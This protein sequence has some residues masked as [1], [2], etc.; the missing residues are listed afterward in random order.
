MKSELLNPSRRKAARRRAFDLR[1][2]RRF[3]EDTHGGV[4]A[5]IGVMLPILLA[6]SGLALDGSI[7]YAQKR[8]VQAIADT[9]AYSVMLEVQRVGNTD[10]AKAAAKFDALAYGFDESAGDSITFNIPP[11][12]GAFANT[13]GYY[14]VIVERPAAVF[15]TGLI[16]SDFNT[17][18][19]AVSGGAAG[20]P[21]PCLLASD[22]TMKDA[23]K[24]NNGTVNTTGCDIQVNSSDDSALNV[25]KN[26]TLDADPINIV[27]DYVKKG[28]ITSTPNVDMPAIG[29][30]LQNLATPSFSP[31][32]C[33]YTDVAYSG[34]SHTLGPGVYCGGIDLSG[35]AQVTMTSG[36]Y[37]ISGDSNDSL[38]VTGQAAVTGN[39][40]TAYFAGDTSLSVNG[41]GALTLTAPTSGDYAGILFHGDPASDPN[42]EH[43]VTGNGS[44]ILDGIMYFP[45]AI[46]KING[47]GNTTS[48]SEISA[49]MARQLRFGG[50]GTLNFHISEDAVLPPVLQSKQTLV[51]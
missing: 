17:A 25:A 3:A 20:S 13:Q 8:S 7:W 47:N 9:A 6:V 5:Y 21:P 10:L 30:P 38:S 43:M 37:I 22:P 46:A 16:V 11:T 33:D 24:V 15:L 36:T 51:E 42:T 40:I 27:G 48:N 19:R 1:F 23:F 4:L 35:D 2:L 45:N 44:A 49:I 29:D 34:G 14:E 50:N 41:Q 32:N 28:T 18:A 12:S 31:S 26:G 39:G